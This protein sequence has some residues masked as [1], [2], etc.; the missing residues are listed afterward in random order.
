MAISRA[1]LL[2]R[3]YLGAPELVRLMRIFFLIILL[4]ATASASANEESVF[5]CSTIGGHNYVAGPS[6]DWIRDTP[7]W[8]PGQP[9]PITIETAVAS[10]RAEIE[11]HSTKKES[12]SFYYLDILTFRTG[13]EKDHWY[14]LVEFG[15]MTESWESARAR[16]PVNMSGIACKLIE[17]RE[18]Q[19]GKK[20]RTSAFYRQQAITH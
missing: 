8:K 3:C 2:A 9:L 13:G 11:K 7:T 12:W 16:I 20:G 5:W 1:A 15:S 10:A 17:D 19:K 18:P 4:I 6:W 14:F